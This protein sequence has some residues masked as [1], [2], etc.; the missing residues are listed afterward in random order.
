MG[1]KFTEL[2]R[3]KRGLRHCLTPI[4]SEKIPSWGIATVSSL[5]TV[6]LVKDMFFKNMS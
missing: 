3:N 2:S 5:L 4:H 1:R 6:I